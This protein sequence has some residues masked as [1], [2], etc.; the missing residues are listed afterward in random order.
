VNTTAIRQAG[1][2]LGFG[3]AIFTGNLKDIP[4]P[5]SE[6]S[7]DRWF[8]TNAGF[9]KVSSQQLANSIRTFPLRFSGVR[10]D[11]QASW[12]FSLLKDFRFGER[13]SAQFRA[14][15]YNA[16][17]HPNFDVPNTTPTNSSFG[18]STQAVS[19][20]RNWQFALRFKF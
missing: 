8:N 14:E 15:L 6:R 4:L 13:A 1:A 2:P 19:E 9:N 16:G 11:G 20:P 12:N 7:A 17:N 18:I 10:S 5:K 3:N